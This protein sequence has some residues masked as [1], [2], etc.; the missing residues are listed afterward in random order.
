MSSDGGFT[1]NSIDEYY[2]DGGT[3]I[4][5]PYDSLRY[6]SGGIRAGNMVVSKTT[7]NGL[8]WTRYELANGY[9]YALAID[10]LNTN[11]VFAGGNPSLFKTTDGGESWFN[12]S[13]GLSGHVYAIAIDPLN[14]NIVYTGTGEG[15]FKSTNG[16]SSWTN[17]GCC[18]VNAILINPLETNTVYA[19]TDS[20][21]YKSTNGGE[22]WT[23][24][25]DGFDS[26]RVTSLGIYPG[27][28]LYAGT[29][30]SSMYVWF[31]QQGVAE[32]ETMSKANR[33]SIYPNPAI[34]QI[35][36]SYQIANRQPISLA[37]YDVQ[38]RK[39]KEL[40]N[41]KESV[42]FHTVKW[43]G[44]DIKG[45]QKSNNIYFISFVAGD[46]KEI[47]KIILLR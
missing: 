30:G 45:R 1:W 10:P 11:V 2:E 19:G 4:A 20:G 28:S 31:F 46:Y 38:G 6:W 7:D 9:T 27:N 26:N 5:D 42:G 17:Y 8:S 3:L 22:N 39:I 29:D 44:I 34:G 15:V 32:N 33:V 13:T 23:I 47:R 40:I 18:D 43:D 36:I 37:V 35:N 12:S 25:N 16:G 21:V 41:R 24:M 14:S